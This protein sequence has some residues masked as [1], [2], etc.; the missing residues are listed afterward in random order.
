[1]TATGCARMEKTWFGRCPSSWCYRRPRGRNV[2][3]AAGVDGFSC[4]FWTT[5]QA[6]ADD[7]LGRRPAR[8]HGQEMRRAVWFGTI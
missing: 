2:S 1:M 4:R 5:I 8:D 3:D 7:G 6:H